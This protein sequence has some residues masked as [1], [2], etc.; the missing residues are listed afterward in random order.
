MTAAN[1]PRHPD[2]GS[3]CPLWRRP[4]HKVCHTCAWW[5][6]VRGK[7]PQTGADVDH[8]SCAIAML[9]MLMIEG[10]QANRQTTATV[11]QLRKEVA[12]S[13]DQSMV[14]AIAHL[15]QRL[16]TQS[17]VDNVKLLEVDD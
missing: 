8:W 2:D 7:H 15:N 17:A 14:G 3:Y 4:C 5:Q 11:D 1:R 10:T 13:H 9:P 12:E 6:H 16:V